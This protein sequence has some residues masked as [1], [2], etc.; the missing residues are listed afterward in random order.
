M[1]SV[2]PTLLNLKHKEFTLVS[3]LPFA[4]LTPPPSR[5]CEIASPPYDVVSRDEAKDFISERPDS[6]MRVTRVDALLEP[7]ISLYSE[8][9]YTRAATEFERLL[10]RGAL[11]Q[12]ETC[13]YAYAQT[14]NTKQGLHTQLGLVGVASAHD[15]QAGRIKRHEL[16]LPAKEDDRMR[17]IKGL[18][19]HLGPVFLTYRAQADI[20]TILAQVT[21]SSPTVEFTAEDGVQHQVWPIS[22]QN[23]M[24]ALTSCFQ[25]LDALYIA[26]GHHRAAAAARVGEGADTH[27][28]RAQFLA[29][30]F[31]HTQLYL[32]PYNRVV[33]HL[34]GHSPAS[35]LEALKAQFEVQLLQDHELHSGLPSSE[36]TH[37][38]EWLMC[39]SSQWYRLTMKDQLAEKVKRRDVKAQLA[40]SVLQDELLA[41]LLGV[42]DPRTCTHID[43]VGGIRGLSALAQETAE[44]GVAFAL[45]PTTTQEVMEIA[46]AGEVMPPKSTWFEPKLRSGLF[47]STFN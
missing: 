17:L 36:P 40:V 37:R 22:D 34:N 18:K 32:M 3:Y 9:A 6:L 25:N 27:D 8:E 24:Q 26:D 20:D 19:A 47:V 16:T 39:L 5:A 38:Y 29:V 11:L 13:Y 31:P 28:P 30:A 21:S 46:D 41:P 33:R 35:F 45:Y 23:M 15:Y 2:K 44:N 42:E 43:F 4:A 14:M 1:D 7:D 10:S 12:R